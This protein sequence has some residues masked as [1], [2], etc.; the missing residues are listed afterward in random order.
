MKR[1]AG[2]WS[3]R[4]GDTALVVVGPPCTLFSKSGP[5]QRREGQIVGR[6][7]YRLSTELIGRCDR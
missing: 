6:T 5:V 2:R 1:V 3:L 7:A 4:E